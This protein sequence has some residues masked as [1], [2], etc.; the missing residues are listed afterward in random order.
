MR[1]SDACE[2]HAKDPNASIVG[3]GY[4]GTHSDSALRCLVSGWQVH[5]ILQFRW[6]RW[7]LEAREEWRYRLARVCSVRLFRRL[8]TLYSYV[9]PFPPNLSDFECVATLEGHDHEVKCVAWSPSGQ[10]LATCS[11]DK[12]VWIWESDTANQGWRPFLL[13]HCGFVSSPLCSE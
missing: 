11:R 9:V 1:S 13:T 10:L 5:C 12:T 4:V 7:N 6:H 2:L 3:C 8:A